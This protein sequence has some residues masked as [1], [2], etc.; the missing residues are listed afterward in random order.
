MGV[1]SSFLIE[2]ACVAWGRVLFL[3]DWLTNPFVRSIQLK[4]AKTG[5]VCHAAESCL[6]PIRLNYLILILF[7]LFLFFFFFYVSARA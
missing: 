4:D 5:V 2:C 6:Q 3:V 1:R 7:S